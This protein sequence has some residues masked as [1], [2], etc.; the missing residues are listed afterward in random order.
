MVV[1]A[2]VAGVGIL[3]GGSCCMQSFCSRRSECATI[4]KNGVDDSG[5]QGP[6]VAFAQ[7]PLWSPLKRR[8]PQPA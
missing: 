4:Y 7:S 8:P 5:R 6:P 2:D 3:G 1:K